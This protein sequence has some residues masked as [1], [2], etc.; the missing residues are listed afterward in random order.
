MKNTRFNILSWAWTR[1]K[2]TAAL[3]KNEYRWLLVTFWMTTCIALIVGALGIP[4]GIGGKAL[5][6]D[7]LAAI[8]LGSISYI[9]IIPITAALLSFLYLPVPRLATAGLLLSGTV[10]V[11]VLIESNSGTLFSFIAGM[12]YCI[13]CIAIGYFGHKL[14]RTMSLRFNLLL[15]LCLFLIGGSLYA[16][17]QHNAAYWEEDTELSSAVDSAASFDV[18][19]TH[20]EVGQTHN[21]KS[22]QI[23]LMSKRRPL[24]HLSL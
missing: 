6:L 7:I 1:L 2:A 14:Y 22:L 16:W 5:F 23:K 8:A 9:I 13:V 20:M 3:D 11:Y 24:M 10:S 21:G 18:S 12:S 15:L 19:F 17:F 4:T